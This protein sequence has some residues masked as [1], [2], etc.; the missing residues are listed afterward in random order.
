MIG[1]LFEEVNIVLCTVPM[2]LM[3]VEKSKKSEM[4]HQKNTA[5]PK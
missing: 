5:L 1:G 2:C 4:E 3:F